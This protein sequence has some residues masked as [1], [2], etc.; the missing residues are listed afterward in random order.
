MKAIGQQLEKLR[1]STRAVLTM[2]TR[3]YHR[4]PNGRQLKPAG[5][6]LVLGLM[7][8]MLA[9]I[10]VVGMSNWHSSIVGHDDAKIASA[11]VQHDESAPVMP[12]VDLH[13]MTHTVINGLADISPSTGVF[14]D[15]FVV[16][17]IWFITGDYA[18]SGPLPEA[19]LRPP[20]G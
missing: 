1:L 15:L 5:M 20:R 2:L 3:M 9:M 17:S 13:K 16:V 18:L 12:E 8:A 19:L 10:N 4:A 6:S 14:S 7:L 11:L